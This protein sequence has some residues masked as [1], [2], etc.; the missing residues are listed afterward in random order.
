VLLAVAVTVSL[1]V[2]EVHRFDGWASVDPN[3]PIHLRYD[4]GTAA[5]AWLSRLRPG[6]LSGLERAY[7]LH[8]EGNGL[9][10]IRRAPLYRR[11][12][13]WKLELGMS[14]VAIGDSS[15]GSGLA[16]R[17]HLGLFAND[18]IGMGLVLKYEGGEHKGGDYFNMHYG[19][20]L[21]LMPL[22]VGP[23]HAGV[24]GGAGLG[25]TVAGG[26]SLSDFEDHTVGYEAGGVV[27][28][29]LSTR[30]ALSA[31][32]GTSWYHR[33]GGL[34]NSGLFVLGGLSIY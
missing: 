15:L 1:A 32:V 7:L 9:T 30:L 23:V 29:E 2:T 5:A 11:G 10:L 22:R 4:D 19:L 17:M 28:F 21:H 27:E 14:N 26:G 6:D 33:A 18:L 20:D 13:S 3:H 16:A 31:K 25:Y 34:E 12:G 24:F 8:D